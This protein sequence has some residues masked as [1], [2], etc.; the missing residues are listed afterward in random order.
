MA[1]GFHIRILAV[2]KLVDNVENFGISMGQTGL[3]PGI[4]QVCLCIT[5]CIITEITGEVSCYVAR[6]TKLFFG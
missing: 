1:V 2:D 4:T 6:K 3:L 5:A